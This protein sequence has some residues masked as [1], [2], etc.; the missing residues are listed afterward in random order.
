MFKIAV[1]DYFKGTKFAKEI[2]KVKRTC[3]VDEVIAIA[4]LIDKASSDKSMG[5]ELGKPKIKL[6]LTD[7]MSKVFNQDDTISKGNIKW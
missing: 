6:A 4:R 7:E 2:K 1:N 5:L 3:I